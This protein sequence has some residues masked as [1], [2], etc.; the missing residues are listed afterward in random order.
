MFRASTM[1]VSFLFFAFYGGG[2]GGASAPDVPD[3]P[4]SATE[5]QLRVTQSF[6]SRGTAYYPDAS[7]LEGGFVDRRGAPLRTL[8][9]F[10]AGEADYV[11]VA[12]DTRAFPYRQRLRIHE[13]EAKYE[14]PIVFRVVDTGGAFRNRGT[15]RIDVCV[16]D[17]TASY[18]ATING[19]LHIDALAEDP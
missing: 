6:T 11:S 10:L 18:D 16:A 12:M 13:L 4:T 19:M 15:T 7:P 9:Q 8:Q 3:A 1:V 5:D 14:R 2:C 17:R